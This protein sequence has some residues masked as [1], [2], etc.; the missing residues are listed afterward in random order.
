MLTVIEFIEIGGSLGLY[1]FD[2]NINSSA[3]DI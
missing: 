1:Y 2:L 3:R